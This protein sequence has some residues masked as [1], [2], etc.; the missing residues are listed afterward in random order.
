MSDFERDLSLAA[1]SRW[2]EP[3]ERV[4]FEAGMLLGVSATRTEQDYHR[5]RLTRHQHWLHGSGTVLGLAVTLDS[6]PATGE[7]E[8]TT[9]RILIG[10]GL[11]IDGLGREVLVPGPYCLDLGEWMQ[12]Q[13]SGALRDGRD[14]AGA[15]WLSVTMRFQDC[16]HALQPVMARKVNAGTDPVQPARIRDGVLLELVPELPPTEDGDAPPGWPGLGPLPDAAQAA[17]ARTPAEQARVD[18]A[19]DALQARRLELASRLIYALPP[20]PEALGPGV[21]DPATVARTLLARLRIALREDDSPILNPAHIAVDNLSRPVVANPAQLAWLM[22]QT[23][24]EGT[25]S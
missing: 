17:A 5:R 19:G 22:R 25:P 9:V 6:E 16:P 11:G 24:S 23:L 3:L 15:L 10:P 2:E 1:D 20:E 13:Q 8:D 7:A 21:T 4:F 12:A 18:G 14:G